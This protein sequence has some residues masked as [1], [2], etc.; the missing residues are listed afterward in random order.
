MSTLDAV[1]VRLDGLERENRRLRWAAGVLLVGVMTLTIV[2]LVG[3]R[4]GARTIEAQKL[5]IRD[6]EG[7]IRGS[8]GVDPSGLPGLKIFDRRGLEQID[9]GVQSEDSSTLTFADRGS[10][11]VMLDTSIE[12][13]TALRLFDRTQE[14]QA[15]LLIRPDSS[16]ALEMGQGEQAVTLAPRPDG[17]STQPTPDDHGRAARGPVAMTPPEPADAGPAG[18]WIDEGG[19]GMAHDVARVPSQGER[20]RPANVEPEVRNTLLGM[21]Q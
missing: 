6:R 10:P 3:P 14:L 19:A 15:A 13:S 18:E 21:G 7:R 9:L 17:A 8:F 2:A 20:E 1:C 5:V 12:G 11:R 16:T 4:R